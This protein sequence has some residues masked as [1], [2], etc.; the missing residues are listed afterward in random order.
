MVTAPRAS[1]KMNILLLIILLVTAPV[2]Y[3]CIKNP[4][5]PKA[6]AWTVPLNIGLIDRTWTF[7]QMVAKDPKFIIDSTT[8]SVEY[9][10]SSLVNK[11][12]AIVL[13]ELTPAPSSVSQKLGLVPLTV[14]TIPDVTISFKD[15]FGVDPG[16]GITYLGPDATVTLNN[17][18][19][20]PTATYDYLVFQDGLMTLQITNNFPFAISFQS[21]VQLVNVDQDQ[22]VVANFAFTTIAANSSATKT[23]NVSGKLMSANLK[24]QSTVTTSGASGKTVTNTQTLVSHL[25]IGGTSGGIATLQKAKVQLSVSYPVFNNPDSAVQLIDDSTKIKRA[26]FSDGGFQIK[27]TNDI[28]TSISVGFALKEFVDRVTGAPFKLKNDATGDTSGIVGPNSVFVQTVSM[29]NYA[30]QSQHDTIIGGRLDTLSVPNVN[31]AINIKT[32]GVTQGRVVI[33]KDDS[34]RVD[35]TPLN[36]T[37]SPPRK[38]YILSKVIGKVKPTYVPI[39]ETVDAAIGDIGNKFSADSIKFDSVSITL[40]ILS[41]GAFPTDLI[42]KV[43]GLDNKGARRDS[44]VPFKTGTN[45]PDTLRIYP[46]IQRQV[47]FNKTTSRIDQFLSSFF[48]GGQGSLPSKFIVTGQAVVDPKAYYQYADSTGTV[49]VGDS[50]FTSLDFLFPVRVGIINGVFADTVSIGDT[51]GNKIDK[52]SLALIDSG[53]VIFTITNGFPFQLDVTSKLLPGK[54]T[55]KSIPDT[56]TTLLT[57]PKSGS[58][59]ADSARYASRP[60]SPN[61]L[62]GI[63]I[64]LTR[65]DVSQI[66]PAQFVVVNVHM[67]TSGSSQPVKFNSSYAVRLR[68]YVSV[69]YTIN[70]NSLK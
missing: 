43:I 35:V 64:G 24:M 61:G 59:R 49:K 26:E 18:I 57:L 6:P 67:N 39:N 16:N 8:G 65:N 62:S 19:S 10:P 40:K 44:L 27:I 56:S 48:V 12:T 58:I 29:K 54:A 13:P 69:Q 22:A 30:I 4:M 2:S 52:K 37:Q 17:V 42:M 15:L 51:S 3:R 70:P 63:I 66:N 41:T 50:V 1:G 60:N 31:F 20:N 36:N 55:N 14:P 23:A 9:R 68:G 45:I 47:V 53:N 25:T 34:V 38:T 28:S 11:P 33:S 32:L 21:G 5:K 7:G 46:G